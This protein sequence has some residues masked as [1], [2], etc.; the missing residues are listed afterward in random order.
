MSAAAIVAS[1]ICMCRPSAC[2]TAWIVFRIQGVACME[3]QLPSV[4]CKQEVDERGANKK[5]ALQMRLRT[6]TNVCCVVD[7][8]IV[9]IMIDNDTLV[10]LNVTV[11]ILESSRKDYAKIKFATEF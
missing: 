4:V 9:G 7:E 8:F 1:L 11:V 10:V 6:A 5:E 3:R 2:V